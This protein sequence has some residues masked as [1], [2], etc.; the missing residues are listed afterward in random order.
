MHELG[1]TQDMLDLVLEE[2]K[3]AGAKRV[4]R[5]NLTLG[6]TCGITGES[7]EFYFQMLSKGTIAQGAT[8]TFEIIP[9]LAR[10]RNCRASFALKEPTKLCPHC[11]STDLEAVSGSE[12]SVKSIDVD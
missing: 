9:T 1:I 12:L 8:L 2:A 4:A 10:C 11:G 3:K 5:I 7:V 6:E